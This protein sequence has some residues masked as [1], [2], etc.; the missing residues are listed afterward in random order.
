VSAVALGGVKTYAPAGVSSLG[1]N[2]VSVSGGFGDTRNTVDSTQYIE[3]GT[4]LTAGFCLFRD[5]GGAFH[6]CSTTDANMIAVIRSM[7]GDALVQFTYDVTTNVC[8]YMLSYA[9]SRAQP[10]AP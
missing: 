6:S 8:Q 5:S 2:I 7:S 4:N 10:K 9:S 1:G 3:C